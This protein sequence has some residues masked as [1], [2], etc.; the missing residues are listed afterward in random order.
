MKRLL[1]FTLIIILIL[2]FIGCSGASSDG[3]GGGNGGG[4][5]DNGGLNND[6]CYISAK[7]FKT[8]TD[9]SGSATVTSAFWLGKTEVTYEL[10]NTVYTWALTN[11]YTFSHPGL[12]GSDGAVGKTT[13]HPVT[14]V[15][16][17][18]AIVWC[19]A[20]SLKSGLQPVYYTDAGYTIPLKSCNNDAVS[21]TTKTAG[22]EDNPFVKSNANGYRLPTSNEWELAA[23]FIADNNNDGDITDVGEYYPGNYA[24]GATADY[25]NA[26]ATQLVAWYTANSGASTHEVKDGAKINNLG[27]YDMSGN[28]WEW[29][30]NWDLVN[31]DERI[32]KGGS[33][34]FNAEYNQVGAVYSYQPFGARSYIGFRLAKNN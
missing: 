17:R 22:N 10:W 20:Y 13:N 19:N 8:N 3:G 29:C 18:D 27:I 5:G 11:G 33:W 9:D 7:S 1:L 34:D 26:I 32:R 6:M 25:S 12:K 2:F 30:F 4:G 15:S 28:V 21:S 31:T 14:T 24:S 16:W 23:R